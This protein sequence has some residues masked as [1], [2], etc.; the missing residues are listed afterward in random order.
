MTVYERNLLK[1]GVGGVAAGA[2]VEIEGEAIMAVGAVRF[3][4]KNTSTKVMFVDVDVRN[5]NLYRGETVFAKN[6]L[7]AD[8]VREAIKTKLIG[9]SDQIVDIDI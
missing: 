3:Q 8:S 1:N 6:T 4:R 7:R 9:N 5:V 2:C